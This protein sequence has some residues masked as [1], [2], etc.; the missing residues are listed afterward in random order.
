MIRNRPV[1]TAKVT[2]GR[3]IL[4]FVAFATIFWFVARTFV[5]EPK[6][7]H[8]EQRVIPPEKDIP[9][10][11]E[12]PEY[13][14]EFDIN[15]ERRNRP[16]PPFRVYPRV[17]LRAFHPF[18]GTEYEY[19]IILRPDWAPNA[20]QRFIE[21]CDEKFFDGAPAFRV[22][23]DFI[24]QFGI[25]ATPRRPIKPLADDPI[26]VKSNL[27]GTI[28]FA[29][30]ASSQVFINLRDNS[31]LDA[32]GFTPF[33]ELRGQSGGT[34]PNNI[35]AAVRRVMDSMGEN[36]G[37][38]AG[39]NSFYFWSG[40]GEAAPKGQGPT[41][42]DLRRRGFDE[43]MQASFPMMSTILSTEII[44][45]RQPQDKVAADGGSLQV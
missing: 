17:F 10:M 34:D 6:V 20:V 23:P 9:A 14:I 32:K 3:F 43:E 12:G 7:V 8:A 36:A 25:P 29:R 42:A 2:A 1:R 40:Y 19:E 41:Q 15:K 4:L 31:G 11:A 5:L 33:G 38:F 35:T 24:V 27:R 26:N 37:R 13:V 39:P 45:P 21:L 30:P 44:V 28:T 16:R 22:I 18:H